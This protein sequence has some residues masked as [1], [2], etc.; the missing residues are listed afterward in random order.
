MK[1]KTYILIDGGAI[2]THFCAQATLF[3]IK[4]KEG[5]A[6]YRKNRFL[7]ATRGDEEDLQKILYYDCRALRQHDSIEP[8]RNPAAE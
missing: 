7:R 4:A 2:R 3:T 6:N 1:K 8:C 5:A